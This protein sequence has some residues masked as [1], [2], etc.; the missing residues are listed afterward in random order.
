MCS[1][2]SLNMAKSGMSL[3]SSQEL[4][5][6]DKEK[7]CAVLYHCNPSFFQWQSY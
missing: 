3:A 5:E 7:R 4:T 2:Y 1:I 6:V